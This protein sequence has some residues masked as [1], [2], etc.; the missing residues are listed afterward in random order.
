MRT[1]SSLPIQRGTDS[2]WSIPP[3]RDRSGGVA[4]RPLACRLPEPHPRLLDN[5]VVGPTENS[6]GTVR[7]LG[8]WKP[9]Q[10]GN[11]GGRPR[12]VAK[13]VPS[14]AGVRPSSLPRSSWR[15]PWI[16]RRETVTGSRPLLSSSIAAGAR[17]PRSP[18]SKGLIRWGWTRSQPRPNGSPRTAPRTRRRLR[19]APLS[20]ACARA[21][22]W[23]VA[24]A[25][26]RR[27]SACSGTGYPSFRMPRSS[28]RKE[29]PC[30]WFRRS[31]QHPL[32]ATAERGPMGHFTSGHVR[33]RL[34]LR[35]L[36]RNG[37][38]EVSNTGAGLRIEL[39]EPAKKLRG[40]KRSRRQRRD[41]LEARSSSPESTVSNVG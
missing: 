23:P 1:T 8:P 18:A 38:F 28:R 31:R 33:E 27:R 26:S 6:D 4:E 41:R 25:C 36:V 12:G 30:S 35:T 3:A 24:W 19:T 40:K 5:G 13:T 16:P 17:L 7:N 22:Y 37:W 21:R 34:A 32:L 15:S 39:G 14:C 9:G 10:S 11:P 20:G 2:A 29:S